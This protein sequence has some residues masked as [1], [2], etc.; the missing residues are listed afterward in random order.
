MTQTKEPVISINKLSQKLL[1]NELR[2]RLLNHPFFETIRT[3]GLTNDEAG[4]F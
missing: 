4:V 2:E 3:V 1:N